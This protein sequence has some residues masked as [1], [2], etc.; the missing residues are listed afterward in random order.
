MRILVPGIHQAVELE[1]SLDCE[2]GVANTVAARQRTLMIN[3]LPGALCT[4]V[5][6]TW[7]SSCGGCN[8][9]V[10]FFPASGQYMSF[11]LNSFTCFIDSSEQNQISCGPLLSP[12][13]KYTWTMDGT[14]KE[15]SQVC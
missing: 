3:F 10:T 13:G 1:L 8:A 4:M 5:V 12:S 15:F 11:K 7:Q 9:D 2:C 14:Y 6:V